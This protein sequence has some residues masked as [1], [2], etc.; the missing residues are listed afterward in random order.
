MGLPP[1]RPPLRDRVVSPEGQKTTCR[2]KS[3]TDNT[4]LAIIFA[5]AIYVRAGRVIYRR[6][7]QLKGFLNPLNEHPFMAGTV[8]TSIDITVE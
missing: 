1:D 5:F 7:D 6:R 3:S 4:R 2:R 8:T